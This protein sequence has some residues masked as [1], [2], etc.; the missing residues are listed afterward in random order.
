MHTYTFLECRILLNVRQY[1]SVAD[2]V[3]GIESIKNCSGGTNN[4]AW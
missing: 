2:E 4:S 3:T 1:G